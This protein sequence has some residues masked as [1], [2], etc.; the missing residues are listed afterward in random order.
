MLKERLTFI[1]ITFILCNFLLCSICLAQKDPK[2][3][4][5]AAPAA[6]ETD[7]LKQ[8]LKSGEIFN[9]EADIFYEWEQIKK[10][11][12][13]D[14]KKT[15]VFVQT[16]VE[17]G[18]DGELTKS[19]L[20]NRLGAS[21]NEALI[22]CK[23]NHNVSECTSQKLALSSSKLRELDF[24]TKRTMTANLLTTC[25]NK[26]GTCLDSSNSEIRC[27]IYRSP[28]SAK[29]TVETSVPPPAAPAKK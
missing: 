13:S 14:Q 21:K 8:P 6:T 29:T 20:E 19:R 27:Q 2:A 24:Q 12:G 18:M 23:N 5:P 25:E 22:M 17:R 26:A 7:P 16:L 1:S 3:K 15:K 28:D 11:E 9:C 4:E 10:E